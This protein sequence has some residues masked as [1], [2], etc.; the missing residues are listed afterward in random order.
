M[1]ILHN[2]Y[3]RKILLFIFAMLSMREQQICFLTCCL[4]SVKK[5]LSETLREAYWT[6]ADMLYMKL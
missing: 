5:P 1:L 3:F 4:G 2:N 6:A